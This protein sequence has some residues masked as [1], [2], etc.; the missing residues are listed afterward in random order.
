MNINF[1]YMR[2]EIEYTF[3]K[4]CVCG[5]KVTALCVR[6]C[7]TIAMCIYVTKYI[8]GAM[9]EIR[10]LLHTH[11]GSIFSNAKVRGKSIITSDALF[12]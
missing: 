6:I 7:V 8:I 1:P 4:C 9:K 10:K 12:D 5:W 2:V 11:I 3:V